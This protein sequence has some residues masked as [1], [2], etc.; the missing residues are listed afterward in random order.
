MKNIFIN[1]SVNKDGVGA[2]LA[3]K[4]FGQQ[5]Y[6]TI[7]LIDYQVNQYGQNFA[8]DQFFEI[9]EAISG[10]D[11][12]VIATPVYWSDMSGYLKTFIDRLSDIMDQDVA[13]KSAPLNGTKFI[14]VAQGTAPEDAFSG[15]DTVIKRVASRFYM[16]YLG[17]VSNLKDVKDIHFY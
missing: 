5:K 15:I 11:Q 4:I 17:R 10:V 7:D 2:G 14:M 8:G 1:T 9:I 6:T 16:D 12:L 13:A 3:K